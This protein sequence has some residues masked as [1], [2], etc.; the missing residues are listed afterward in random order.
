M[1]YQSVEELEKGIQAYIEEKKKDD[2]PLTMSG[3]AYALGIDRGTL[4]NYSENEQFFSTVKRARDYVLSTIEEGLMKGYNATGA[5][6]NLKNN[7]GWVDKTEQD[8]TSKGQSIAPVSPA[9]AKQID[10]QLEEDV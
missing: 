4:L 5:I 7:F 6:F 10:K 1:K 8:I 3:L 2:K 9:V